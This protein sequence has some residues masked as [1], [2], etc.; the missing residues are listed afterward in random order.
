[1]KRHGIIP[2]IFLVIGVLLTACSDDEPEK[3]PQI[4]INT[5]NHTTKSEQVLIAKTFELLIK[6]CPMVK[7]YLPSFEE[8]RAD[9]GQPYNPDRTS[10]HGWKHEV[11]FRFVVKNKPQ[12]GLSRANGHTLYLDVGAG[13]APGIIAQK[14]VSQELC[15]FPQQGR[16]D[17]DTFLPAPIF[18][19][20]DQ[21]VTTQ[22]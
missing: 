5:P 1:M 12:V 7:R 13:N 6:K 4:T 18:A 9:V 3:L 2:G 16:T 19:D 17:D 21:L 14:A 22:K 10:F 8:I 11:R 15:P 20:I